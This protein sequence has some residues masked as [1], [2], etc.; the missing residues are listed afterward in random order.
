MLS[1]QQWHIYRYRY[2]KCKIR[3][4]M[5][6]SKQFTALD[7]ATF[8]LLYGEN[9]PKRVSRYSHLYSSA[10]TAIAEYHR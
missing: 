2:R 7:V 9:G 3:I 1:K 4:K 8:F 6:R 5:N 10:R